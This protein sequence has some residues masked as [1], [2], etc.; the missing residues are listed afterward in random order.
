MKTLYESILSSTKSGKDVVIPNEIKKLIE[1]LNSDI[2]DD[3]PQKH[4]FFKKNDFLLSN[5]EVKKLAEKIVKSIKDKNSSDKPKPGLKKQ[6]DKGV[7]CFSQLVGVRDSVTY[8]LFIGID[9]GWGTSLKKEIIISIDEDNVYVLDAPETKH[10][11]NK[12]NEYF[13]KNIKSSHC[14]L[15]SESGKP[16]AKKS[17]IAAPYFKYDYKDMKKLFEND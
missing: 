15:F 1:V 6:L 5:S 11:V 14:I 17:I 13:T 7:E 8:S 3:D 9:E 16:I 12:M 10:I 4:Q 2:F